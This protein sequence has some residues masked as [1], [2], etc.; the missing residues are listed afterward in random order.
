M[1]LSTETILKCS[2]QY[3]F[4]KKDL[5]SVDRVKMPF[6]VVQGHRPMYT[7]N[8][9]VRDHPIREKMLEHLEQL[10]VDNKVTN[11]IVQ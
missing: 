9:E 10:L 11:V 7:T 1:Y 6:V 5:E 3:E 4:L 2:E 8:N